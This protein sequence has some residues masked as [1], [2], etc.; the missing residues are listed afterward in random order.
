M[1]IEVRSVT[2]IITNSS[3]E[4]YL[5]IGSDVINAIKSIGNAA[6]G[7]VYN[8]GDDAKLSGKKTPK[9]EDIFEIRFVYTDKA[10]TENLW[11]RLKNNDDYK[12]CK[13][14]EEFAIAYEDRENYE[15]PIIDSFEV[16]AKNPRFRDIAKALNE[17]NGAYDARECEC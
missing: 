2:D 6:I 7:L 12:G 15:L 13:T 4:T 11:N 3:S 17:F 14:L 1:Q 16:V 10:N 8:S 5:I 9:F